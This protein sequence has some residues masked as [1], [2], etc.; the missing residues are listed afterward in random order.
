V[1]R[2]LAAGFLLL[3]LSAPAFAKY[4]C[5]SGRF[6][7]HAVGS[8]PEPLR[9]GLPLE[10]GTGRAELV[11]LC[12]TAPA[13]RFL[14]SIGRWANHVRVRWPRCARMPFASLRAR[15]VPDAPFCTRLHG[16][17]R[18]GGRKFRVVAD[19]E[20]SCGN[21]LR[22]VGE[23]CDG[24]DSDQSGTCCNADCTV[25]PGCLVHCD[26]TYFPCAA[27]DMC[28]P[29]CWAPSVCWPRARLDCGAGPVCGCDAVT[30]YPNQCA[31]F[32]AGT[33]VSRPAACRPQTT[34]R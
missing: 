22:E 10:L 9:S 28:V 8:A 33:G 1:P 5:P 11:G 19:R 17:L 31:A 14:H 6:V 32:E 16:T 21:G 26:R 20:P 34:V 7:V 4:I 13:G 3:S 2:A 12:P 30:T 24:A 15:F 27:G 23:Q 29:S 25:K 18:L